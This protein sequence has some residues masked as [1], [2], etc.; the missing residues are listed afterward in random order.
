MTVMQKSLCQLRLSPT[1][2]A[3]CEVTLETGTTE[4]MNSIWYF[5]KWRDSRE[6][7]KLWR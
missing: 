5:L 4:E 1:G 6:R 7:E 2:F 3:E